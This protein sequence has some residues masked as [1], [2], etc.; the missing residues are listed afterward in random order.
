MNGYNGTVT[1]LSY[2]EFEKKQ[3]TIYSVSYYTDLTI[4][5]GLIVEVVENS[6]VVRWEEEALS[7]E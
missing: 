1:L 4:V 3:N 6:E 7:R 2:C 5:D